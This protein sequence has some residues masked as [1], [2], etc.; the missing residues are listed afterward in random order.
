MGRPLKFLLTRRDFVRMSAVFGLAAVSGIYGCAPKPEPAPAPSP[1]P[2]PAPSPAPAPA[3]Q[4]PKG[5]L[6]VSQPG[7]VTSLDP[8]MQQMRYPRGAMAS[9]YDML[10][11]TDHTWTIIPAVAKSWEL[12]DE[13][14][15]KFNLRD[16]VT[17]H[18]G[19]KLTSKDVK[20]SVQR[21]TDPELNIYANI[22][23]AVKEVQT[24]DDYTAI[25]K[26]EQPFPALLMNLG[27]N[28]FIGPMETMQKM[29][30]DFFTNPI[31]SGTFEFS[32][33]VPGDR[34]VVKAGKPH[35][36][37]GPLAE[38]VQWVFGRDDTTRLT[39][40]K[41]GHA[42]IVLPVPPDRA[43]EVE[44]APDLS[45]VSTDVPHIFIL[46][47]NC[48]LAPFNNVK[49]RQ[50]MQYAIDR[51]AICERLFNNTAFPLNG[52]ISTMGEGHNGELQ[53]YPYDPERARSL[54]AEAG[55][56][57]GFSM[58]Y[59]VTS[60][61]YVKESE[62]AQAVAGFFGDVGINVEIVPY[63]WGAYVEQLRA[64]TWEFFFIRQSTLNTYELLNSCLNS[65]V[66]GIPWLHYTNEQVN[67]LI[68]TAGKTMDES[69]R[70]TM[71]KDASRIIYED[72]PWIFLYQLREL[73]GVS[74]KLKG[75]TAGGEMV[76]VFEAYVD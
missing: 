63:E 70:A 36:M 28:L 24:P 44:D 42:H 22:L 32:S 8:H 73:V 76:R 51:N 31:G 67:G 20:W 74:K 57:N 6:I 38:E 55:Y 47:P 5:T 10:V 21:Y 75:Y 29:G 43:R 66:K 53:P 18:D 19:S 59:N 69:K 14:T 23:A 7:D 12:V 62:V 71:Y 45:V 37:G 60:G 9:L 50:A 4:G 40:L 61:T 26:T 46:V 41:T 34:L 3:P 54:L 48:S 25:M 49:V 30:K 1:A 2:A 52:P 33:W 17:F 16:D 35:F 58:K 68:E 39:S 72:S 11:T 27:F 15:W 65:R 13:L 56:P 64:K